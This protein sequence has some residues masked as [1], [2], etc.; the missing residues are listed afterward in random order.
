M[1]IYVRL[2]CEPERKSRTPE[3]DVKFAG[4]DSRALDALARMH[5]LRPL[6]EFGLGMDDNELDWDAI[7]LFDPREAIRT[8]KALLPILRQPPAPPKGKGRK[9]FSE[10]AT[11]GNWRNEFS[12]GR[13]EIAEE[14]EELLRRLE[15]VAR[16]KTRFRFLNVG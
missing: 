12:Y 15:R 10:N 14:L 2:M 6:G 13:G 4:Y 7:P 3:S 1:G 16:G 9:T 11:D 8:I 5:S